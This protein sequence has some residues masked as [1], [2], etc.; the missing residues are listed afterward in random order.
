MSEMLLFAAMCMVL[1]NGIFS[2]IRQILYKSLLYGN[3]KKHKN[4][5]QNRNRFTYIEN[6]LCL[7]KEKSKDRRINWKLGTNRYK[8]LYIK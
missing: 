2:E 8:L 1:E 5:I 6:K 7:L 3:Q 4:S